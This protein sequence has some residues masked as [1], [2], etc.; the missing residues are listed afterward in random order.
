MPAV[1]GRLRAPLREH[2]VPP[3]ECGDSAAVARQPR[4]RG[5]G[6]ACSP[7]ESDLGVAEESAEVAQGGPDR[8]PWL[9]GAG[10]DGDRAPLLLVVDAYAVVDRPRDRAIG[11][12]RVH[13]DRVDPDKKH[14]GRAVGGW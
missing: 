10:T 7:S 6:R 13:G 8:R 12:V 9:S 4:P 3:G 1:G 14:R 2:M 11:E 5:G